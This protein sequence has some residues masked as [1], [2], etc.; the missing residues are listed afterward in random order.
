[1]PKEGKQRSNEFLITPRENTNVGDGKVLGFQVI[2]SKDF[3]EI[4]HPTKTAGKLEL[5]V[6]QVVSFLNLILRPLPLHEHFNTALNI[7][8]LPYL[9]RLLIS[10]NPLDDSDKLL[11]FSFQPKG[12]FNSLWLCLYSLVE[13]RTTL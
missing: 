1:M 6:S 9:R 3:V 12:F 2:Q 4:G 10:I 8:F 5:L 11:R 7:R 13:Q